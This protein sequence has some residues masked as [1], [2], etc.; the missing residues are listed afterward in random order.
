MQDSTREVGRDRS[1]QNGARNKVFLSYR[2]AD[3]QS[4][5]G[6]LADDL[7]EYLG[8]D[9]IYRDVDAM[10]KGED[11]ERLIDEAIA[12]S[13][14]TV[15][16]V[17]PGWLESRSAD[18]KRRLDE[19][20][21]MVRME[22]E[23]S[24]KSGIAIVPVLVGGARMP[25]P[26]DLP[27]SLRSFARLDAQVLRDEDWRYDFGRLLETLERYGVTAATRLTEGGERE[28]AAS[29]ARRNV[30]CTV[31]YRRT[32]RATRRRAYDAVVGAVELLRYPRSE[33]DPEAAEVRFSALA[34]T[35]TVKVVDAKPGESTVV[36]EFA[37]LSWLAIGGSALVIMPGVL[38]GAAL[39]A[40]DS[41][42][43]RGFLDN[44]QRVLEGKGV[45]RDSA[46]L[47]GMTA[48]REKLEL[49]EH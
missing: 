33:E 47:P 20:H 14:V 36:V 49:A 46:R 26:G 45:G 24:L 6:R 35:V 28:T 4:W 17:G 30:I 18:G 42:F 27:H 25:S 31:R 9:R 12:T 44:A 21:D 2:R 34:R 32:L 16:I 13:R 15:A 39:K 3:S 11:Y 19:P 5:T 48:L 1:R 22:L 37:S 41:Y 40:Q 10:R 7:R 8:A 29:I 23:H 38:L 43:A